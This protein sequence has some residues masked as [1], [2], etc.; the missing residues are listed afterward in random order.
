MAWVWLPV[1]VVFPLTQ[2]LLR[3]FGAMHG[4]FLSD[5]IIVTL[6]VL[7]LLLGSLFFLLPISRVTGVLGL[8][9]QVLK[10]R[11]ALL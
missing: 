9:R 1:A 3:S 11:G 8:L 10:T 7:V 2:V 5:I 4:K 6:Q